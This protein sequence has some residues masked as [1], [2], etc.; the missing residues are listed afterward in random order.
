M[1]NPVSWLRRV[2]LVEGVSFL[3]LLGVAMP[4]KYLGGMP[5]AVTVVGWAHGLL[6]ILVLHALS[7]AMGLEGWTVRRS[8]AVVLAALLPAGPF[9]LDRRMRAWEAGASARTPAA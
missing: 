4:L 8:A 1:K 7:L 3:V 9:V 5:Q 2:S 6:F